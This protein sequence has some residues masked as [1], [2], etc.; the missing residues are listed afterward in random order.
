MP[1]F[2]LSELFW[3]SN[4]IAR[5]SGLAFTAPGWGLSGVTHKT[6][7]VLAMALA[8]V[9]WPAASASGLTLLTAF[10]P[11]LWLGTCAV[12][13][14][15]GAGLGLSGA[16]VISGLRQAGE[17][18]AAQAGLSPAS[19]LEMEAGFNR[20]EAATP[21]GHLYGLIAM[22]VFLSWNGPLVLVDALAASYTRFPLGCALGSAVEKINAI[23]MLHAMALTLFRYTQV[24]LGFAL[25]AAAPAG[26]ALVFAGAVLAVLTRQGRM[27]ALT[28]LGWP[29]RWVLGMLVVLAGLPSLIAAVQGAW[30]GWRA[31]LV[32]GF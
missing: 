3:I 26:L 20:S 7:I 12:E 22:V 32:T 17:L 19:V 23:T 18:V 28:G 13:F 21:F 8:F 30:G 1:E 9:L 15:I 29:A 27:A 4:L 25:Q 11:M 2:G 6:R 5:A 16:L 24:C 14:A 31:W 10:E